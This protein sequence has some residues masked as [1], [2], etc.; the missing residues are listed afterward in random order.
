MFHLYIASDHIEID[1][2]IYTAS[3]MGDIHEEVQPGE[4]WEGLTYEE[5]LALGNGA[6]SFE[7]LKVTS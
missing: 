7:K 6:H 5:L 2:A 1:M 3:S 4:A